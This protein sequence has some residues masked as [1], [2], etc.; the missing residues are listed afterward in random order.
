MK[1]L[2]FLFRTIVVISLV[3]TVT[4]F[5]T[6]S[7]A[8]GPNGLLKGVYAANVSSRCL[9]TNSFLG[10][11]FNE[12]LQLEPLGSEALS[13]LVSS[14]LVTYNGDGT[15]H[16]EGQLMVVQDGNA[17]VGDF[18]GVLTFDFACDITYT[19]NADRSFDAS[20]M[21]TS[22]GTGV[23]AGVIVS[24]TFMHSGF[25]QEGNRRTLITHDVTPT[26]NILNVSILAI[27]FESEFT[28]ICTNSGTQIKI[29]N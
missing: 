8:G 9:A 2:T 14:F 17:S 26:E 10:T 20:S 18:A 29:Q 27:P 15:A 3:L 24:S 21:C 1:N 12:S 5:S 25:I 11:F 6:L 16:S 23:Q 28:Q 19:V 4:S 22:N 13:S 7:V